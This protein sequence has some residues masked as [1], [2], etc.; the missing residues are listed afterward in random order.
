[1]DGDFL[2]R[3]AGDEVCGQLRPLPVHERGGVRG[4]GGGR[5]GDGDAGVPAADDGCFC[6]DAVR[7]YRGAVFGD[8][9]GERGG[10]PVRGAD[11]PVP[12]AVPGLPPLGG[13]GGDPGRGPARGGPGRGRVPIFGVH[14][15]PGARG[16]GVRPAAGAGPLK[17]SGRRVLVGAEARKVAVAARHVGRCMAWAAGVGARVL[18]G[19]LRA[20]RDRR[21]L[22]HLG[23]ADRRPGVPLK[24]GVEGA[25]EDG[26]Q[27]QEDGDDDGDGHAGVVLAALE[28]GGPHGRPGA[29]RAH[30]GRE[31]APGAVEALGADDGRVVQG[32]AGV[33][34]RNGACHLPRGGV[35]ALLIAPGLL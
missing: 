33:A 18:D 23:H 31:A 25:D 28:V 15:R 12:R 3:A 34:G 32:G 14:G 29:P 17:F 26:Q 11:G 13:G 20:V 1:M 5:Q 16:A 35:R 4:G 21:V 22:G 30:P 10:G 24:G 7:L 8:P 6:G 19:L 9:R 27:D 2:W